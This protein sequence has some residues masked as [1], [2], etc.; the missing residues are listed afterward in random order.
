MNPM[1]V[2]VTVALQLARRR[3]GVSP[4]ELAE[5]AGVSLRHAQEILAA[6][7][8]DGVLAVQRPPRKGQPLGSWRN[9]YRLAK[10]GSG[11]R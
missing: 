8:G 11:K 4:G 6:L 3:C 2:T 5:T 9:V 7:V 10:D 1:R